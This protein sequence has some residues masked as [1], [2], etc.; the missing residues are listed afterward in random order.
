MSLDFS[1]LIPKARPSGKSITTTPPKAGSVKFDDL[2]P[3]FPETITI[4]P[5]K[6]SKPKAPETKKDKVL[7]FLNR[8]V[9][10]PQKT[11]E[12]LQKALR[13]GEV[14]VRL[15]GSLLSTPFTGAE[16]ARQKA[17]DYVLEPWKGGK[18]I[19]EHAIDLQAKGEQK[20]IPGAKFFGPTT[21]VGATQAQL[22]GD[23]LNLLLGKAIML[24]KPNI[25]LAE[26]FLT[27][28]SGKSRNVFSLND[29]FLT[30]H[31]NYY[32]KISAT[33]AESKRLAS[34]LKKGF[35]GGD[36]IPIT[37]RAGEKIPVAVR[38]TK[39][40][41]IVPS[42]R[43]SG[44]FVPESFAKAK[45]KDAQIG[46]A[47]G[48]KDITRFIQ[49]IDK[50]VF[51]GQAQKNILWR[52]R[53]M[54]MQ[55]INWTGNTTR[56]LKAVVGRIKAGSP[57]AKVANRVLEKITTI[58]ANKPL[59]KLLN[60][61]KIKNIT[62]NSEVVR[63]AR[64]TRRFLDNLLDSQNA[65]RKLRGQSLIPKRKTYS[66]HQ[67]QDTAL[68]SEVLGLK[69]TPKD[70]IGVPQLPDYIKPNAPFN[71]RALA[72]EG[73]MPEYLREMDLVKLLERYTSTAAKDI[74]N[75]SVVQNN[76]A[77]IQQLDTMGL[78]NAA[79][80]IENWTAE[81][82]AGVKPQM[83]RA[84]NLPPVVERMMRGWRTHFISNIFPLNVS[85]NVFVQTSSS[86]LTSMR[87]GAKNTLRGLVEYLVNPALRH[88][89]DTT[90]YA[91]LV[92]GQKMGKITFQDVGGNVGTSVKIS[93][94]KL[95][96]ARDAGNIFTEVVERILT[97][98][99]A[100]AAEL[101]G[102]AKGIV[103]KALNQ[104]A[105]EGA[106]KTQSM[107]NLE[108]VPGILRS[109]SVKTTAPFQTFSFEMFNTMKEFA[110]KGGVGPTTFKERAGWII[111]FI[112]G[113]YAVNTIGQTTIGRK[114]WELSSFI[115][116][117]GSFFRPIEKA[118][119]G[120]ETRTDTRSLPS[121]VGIA[122]ETARAIRIAIQEGNYRPLRQTA[123]RYG[124][125][126]GGLQIARVVDGV[127][128][129]A[130]GYAVTERGHKK[131]DVITPQ[132]KIRVFLMGTALPPKDKELMEKMKKDEK[133]YS[134]MRDDI[135]RTALT[136]DGDEVRKKIY[137]AAEKMGV[138]PELLLKSVS[139]ALSA[140]IEGKETTALD[141]AFKSLPIPVKIQVLQYL[142]NN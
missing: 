58:D 64:D 127:E 80:G 69:K 70:V 132:D 40:G 11:I 22:F 16:K 131:F 85:W 94:G 77:F 75:T 118:V 142:Q 71:P 137:A 76:K 23:P 135:V 121:F 62:K 36:D 37:T 46:P 61:P 96:T 42:V 63:F 106:A 43:K 88:R 44:S 67:L 15:L 27:T 10:I 83:D 98:M 82:F 112:A 78:K 52:T 114:P 100:R 103:G 125:P 87:Y 117:Y 34:L 110:R 31:L 119:K 6:S 92:K 128:A 2:I 33:P 14:S 24:P 91:P 32:K 48:T 74:F 56:Q 30:K 104:Y 8:R 130:N 129:I 108:D 57:E 123:I 54:M 136:G 3:S 21:A 1:D 7:D 126:L 5:P 141:R 122:T 124:M 19:A 50:G 25:G 13:T 139:D 115:P 86:I 116:F 20:G 95:Q 41:N 90:M 111:R 140:S 51:G 105:S 45:L 73:A 109:S 93:K 55:K 102:K 9:D 47:G 81:V 35:K 60:D 38:T 120:D 97:G 53:D 26:A 4:T 49:Q 59:I 84:L 79:R 66:P 138:E 18:T 89:I 101:H 133:E 39:G 72:R 99:S 65:A 107:Y 28:P 17:K 12:T 68:W 29:P 113:V 134:I